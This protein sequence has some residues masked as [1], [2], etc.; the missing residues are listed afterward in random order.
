MTRA[1]HDR[2]GSLYLIGNGGSAA[3]ASHMAADA[4]KN[5]F[6]RALA[7]NDIARR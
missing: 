5:G 7:L 1:A 2:D 3:M 6:L 4:C